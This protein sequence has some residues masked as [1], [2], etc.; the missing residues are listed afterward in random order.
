[1]KHNPLACDLKTGVCG[2]AEQNEEIMDFN[3][4]KSEITLYYFTDPICSHCW[5]LEPELRKFI[6]LYRHYFK[7]QTIMGGLLPQWADFADVKNGI[8][9]PADVTEHWQEVGQ[10]S[11]MPINGTV[12]LND[13]LHSSYPPSLVYEVIKHEHSPLGERFL[14]LLREQLFVFNENIAKEDVLIRL[15]NE[16]GLDSDE[17]MKK[18]TSTQGKAWLQEDFNLKEQMG[19]RGFPT[20]VLLD[21]ENR[22]MKLVGQRR[23]EDYISA[24]EKL[25]G[26]PLTA[27]K[28]PS[29]AEVLQKEQRLFAK[30]IEVL[31]DVEPAKLEAFIESEL[32]GGYVAKEILGELYFEGQ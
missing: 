1:M 27:G 16:L 31:Y 20:V 26:K 10:H 9:G 2:N 3:L 4:S 7:T 23:A 19:V 12:W 22:G 13:P 17:I 21:Q 11:R 14:R 28:L 8:S 32:Q 29:L 30:E 5:A 15:V 6:Y 18:A 25:T 24:L